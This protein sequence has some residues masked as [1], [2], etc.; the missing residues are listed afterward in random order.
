[1]NEEEAQGHGIFILSSTSIFF[2]PT[3]SGH[4][5]TPTANTSAWADNSMQCGVKA[6]HEVSCGPM[7]QNTGTST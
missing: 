1:M 3:T 5:S 7:Y 2:E 4:Q 6:N